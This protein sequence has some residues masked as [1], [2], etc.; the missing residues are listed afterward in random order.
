[1]SGNDKPR[2]TETA[3]VVCEDG[4]CSVARP[5]VGAKSTRPLRM[6]GIAAVDQGRA[7]AS[8]SS[9]TGGSSAPSKRPFLVDLLH[10]NVDLERFFKD[11]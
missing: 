5:L 11:E 9:N 2:P 8:A 7:P 10:G 6:L 4:L 1:M 3:E